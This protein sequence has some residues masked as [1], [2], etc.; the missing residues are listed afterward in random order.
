MSAHSVSG[1][2]YFRSYKAK[3]CDVLPKEEFVSSCSLMPQNFYSS[4]RLQCAVTGLPA[5]RG[6]QPG[7]VGNQAAL[8]AEP[9]PGSRLVI[10]RARFLRVLLSANSSLA[11]A[12]AH[13]FFA[14][15]VV[16]MGIEHTHIAVRL[17][18]TFRSSTPLR[19]FAIPSCLT[20][21]C[22]PWQWHTRGSPSA[23]KQM[24]NRFLLAVLTR[25]TA[26]AI[27][28]HKMAPSPEMPF[29]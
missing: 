15:R 8:T 18:P 22:Y 11:A 26:N 21:A 6:S 7:Q 13:A 28:N 3:H 24:V 10:Q 5:W 19:T 9:V 25:Q 16:F 4:N 29:R 17:S 23:S 20:A 2:G 27:G 14:M 12:V 1:T